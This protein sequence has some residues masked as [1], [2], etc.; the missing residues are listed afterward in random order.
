MMKRTPQVDFLLRVREEIESKEP[1]AAQGSPE[2][3][4][5]C[6]SRNREQGAQGSREQPRVAYYTSEEK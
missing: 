6:K 3:L 2:L 5:T 1:R 4:I